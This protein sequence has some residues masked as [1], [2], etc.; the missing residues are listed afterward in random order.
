MLA[1]RQAQFTHPYRKDTESNESFTLVAVEYG[2]GASASGTGNIIEDGDGGPALT[3]SDASA[4]EGANA[5]AT[6]VIYASGMAPGS[7]VT[8][9]TG[10]GTALAGTDYD[11]TSGSFTVDAN[12]AGS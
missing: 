8:Y 3:V 9:N 5:N 10:D 4:T 11:A 12:G 6:F 7:V 2:G 1:A